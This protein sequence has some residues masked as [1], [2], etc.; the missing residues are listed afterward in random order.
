MF[1]GWGARR[2]IEDTIMAIAMHEIDKAVQTLVGSET[3]Y[4]GGD[5]RPG[6]VVSFNNQHYQVVKT[7]PSFVELVR[8][9]D[10]GGAPTFFTYDELYVAKAYYVA[11]V[12]PIDT[13]LA[14]HNRELAE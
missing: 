4:V 6:E 14:A 9:N 5:C 11:V 7:T 13:P 3:L 12:V 2:R 10:S 1:R 8:S